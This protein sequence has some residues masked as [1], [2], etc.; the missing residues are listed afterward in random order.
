MKTGERENVFLVDAQKI[1]D[2][3]NNRDGSFMSN[4]LLW[5]KD[6]EYFVTQIGATIPGGVHIYTG[7]DW[8]GN[9]SVD[10]EW[11]LNNIELPEL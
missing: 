7:E 5:E 8:E 11:V 9:E 10:A 6:G 2:K 1:A 4:F 3:I